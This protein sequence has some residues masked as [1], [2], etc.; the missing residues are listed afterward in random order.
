MMFRRL[1]TIAAGVALSG[2]ASLPPDMTPE[3]S[4]VVVDRA[5]HR[6][7]AGAIVRIQQFPQSAVTTGIDGSF[8]IL[9]RPKWQAALS[10]NGLPGYQLASEAPGYSRTVQRWDVDDDHAQIVTMRRL[11]AIDERDD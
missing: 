8:H 4:G 11:D 2:C 3:L 7:I 1:S 6:P 5:T 9:P 10:V